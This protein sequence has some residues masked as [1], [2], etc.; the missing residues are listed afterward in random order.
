MN[1]YIHPETRAGEIFLTNARKAA[2]SAMTFRTKRLG[3][4]A[5]DG[6]GHEITNN[7]WFPV[8]VT[9]QEVSEQGTT[10]GEIRRQLRKAIAR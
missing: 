3:I 5:R 6:E 10:L 7:D 2:F 9:Q 4:Q 8:F 1:T